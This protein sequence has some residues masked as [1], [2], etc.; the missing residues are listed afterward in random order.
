MHSLV[1]AE[2]TSP[3]SAS[4]PCEVFSM[5]SWVV[6]CPVANK[7]AALVTFQPVEILG[8]VRYLPYLVG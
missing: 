7:K 1:S 2:R 8:K 4:R 5:L 6:G 3:D